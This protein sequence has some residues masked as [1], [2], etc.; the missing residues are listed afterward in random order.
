MSGDYSRER[1]RPR[2]NVSGVRM[3]QGRVQLDSDWN[4]WVAVVDR[5]FRAE[6][7]DLV[8]RESDPDFQGVAVYPRHTPD[9]FE[10]GLTAGVLSIGR[11]RMYVD[12]LLAENHGAGPL[13]FDP[14]LEETR[15]VEAVAYDAQPYFTDPPALPES[16]RALAYL[17][18]WQREVT[19][20]QDPGLVESAVGVDTTTRLQTVWQVRVL[21]DVGPNVTCSTPDAE[22]QGWAAVTRPSAGRLSTAAV[23][24]SED[25]EPCEMPPSGGFRGVE[26]HLYQVRIHDGGPLGTATF[27]WSREN[28]SV[29]SGVVEV[30]SPR[31]LRL[32]SLGRDAVLRFNTGDW[33]EIID[34]RR[35]LAGIDGDPRRRHGEMRQIV[36]NEAT[37]TITF[38]P[39][40]PA[41]LI[42]SGTGDDTADARHLIVR[43]WDQAGS[44]YTSDGVEHFDLDV[45]GS[46]G[47]I[48]VPPAGTTLALESGIEVTFS[49]AEAGG[50]LHTGDYWTFAARTTDASVEELDAAPPRGTHHHYA[51]LGVLTFPDA[52]MD[53]RKPWPPAI[54]TG[55]GGGCGGSCTI[56]ISAEDFAANPN[57]IQ[58]AVDTLR[59]MGGT[60]CLGR[61]VFMLGERRVVI[62]GAR[63]ITIRGQGTATHVVGWGTKFEVNTSFLVALE[64]MQVTQLQETDQPIIMLDQVMYGRYQRLA[65][66][67]ASG[68]TRLESAP[69]IGLNRIIWY[70]DFKENIVTAPVGIGAWAGG[71]D[72]EYVL[73]EGL[74]VDDNIFSTGDY[75]IRLEGSVLFGADVRVARNRFA[76]AS[77]AA[78]T[79]VGASAPTARVEISDNIINGRGA[80]IVAGVNGLRIDRN[81]V[82]APEPADGER[83]RGGLAGIILQPGFDRAPIGPTSITGNRI[84]GLSGPAIGVGAMLTSIDI[85]DNVIRETGG[86]ILFAGAGGGDTVT[87]AGNE[88][89]G[90]RPDR[91]RSGIAAGIRVQR[92]RG[93][94]ITRNTVRDVGDP[95][96]QG[97]VA[98]ILTAGCLEVAVDHNH[99]SRV[100]S[101]NDAT[102]CAGIFAAL[103]FG[104]ASVTDNTVVAD[105]EQPNAGMRWCGILVGAS[106]LGVFQPIANDLTAIRST[107]D[108]AML[109]TENY[110]AAFD[111]QSEDALV[112]HNTVD[113]EGSLPG[114]LVGVQGECQIGDN[115]CTFESRQAPAVFVTASLAAV[116]ANRVRSSDLAMVLHVDVKRSTVVGNI[117]S[118]PIDMDGPL[119]SP[120]DVLNVVG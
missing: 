46:S 70:V 99:V 64:D 109:L 110:A 106:E 104:Q 18:V 40:L 96:A 95:E 80:G 81:E 47:V 20:L 59:E 77:M 87:I 23:G 32:E 115:Q 94:T 116:H 14:I 44:V 78:V 119:F 54:P 4:E 8:G 105:A 55:G 9:A 19:H 88:L 82:W 37:R 12:G 29:A 68:A 74:Q 24:V 52:V 85:Q 91:Q 1:F 2:A 67:R 102:I 84:R 26:N 15:G 120:W 53:C 10:I 60:I 35:E 42:P 25:E 114:I 97:L 63:S 49:L 36:T 57:I 41:G 103:P 89:L 62:E 66:S 33:V 65:L 13:E 112:H 86:G 111:L 11:G 31:E 39:D 27:K 108:R 107:G 50:E 73:L 7:V 17:D 5:H 3:Q 56:C 76:G 58:E 113:G 75:G 16:G 21:P 22:V 71:K 92:V 28:A 38:S 98:G 93:V 83:E 101:R 30:L 43:R 51:R 61:G 79:L 48:P 6:T 117:T 45:P 72:Q 90:I 118:G 34:D 69:A 100:S